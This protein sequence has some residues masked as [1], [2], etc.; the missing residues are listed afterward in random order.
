MRRPVVI[1]APAPA[2][3]VLSDPLLVGIMNAGPFFASLVPASSVPETIPAPTF[4]LEGTPEALRLRAWGLGASHDYRQTRPEFEQLLSAQSCETVTEA[5]VAE[6]VSLLAPE[7][8]G[9][10]RSL[11]NEAPAPAAPASGTPESR[12]LERMLAAARR[13]LTSRP[14]L[15][16]AVSSTALGLEL[17]VQDERARCR[18]ATWLQ[19]ADG[20]AEVGMSVAELVGAVDACL[21]ALPPAPL[22]GE[23]PAEARTLDDGALH[24]ALIG[25]SLAASLGLV[26]GLV[27]AQGSART[28]T[29]LFYGALPPVLGGIGS[30]LVGPRWREPVLLSGFWLG[31]A[32]TGMVVATDSGAAKTLLVGGALAAGSLTSAALAI[33]N[34]VIDESSQRIAPWAVATPAVVGAGLG[35]ASLMIDANG[36]HAG[37]LAL[38]GG[39]AACLPALWLAGVALLGAER[40]DVV[41]VGVR[42][43]DDGPEVVVSGEF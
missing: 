17:T 18:R 4:Q 10:E 11:L 35:A 40:S 7:G 23:A 30:V 25:A 2:T 20:K 1:V 22:A 38:F 5:A 32:G 13:E 26:N 43:D 21:G 16:A 15:S 34:G 41:D 6:I 36:R 29:A 9:F 37:S 3:C 12:A 28:G 24:L 8:D 39:A 42:V 14:D 31:I 27:V 19:F 33:V